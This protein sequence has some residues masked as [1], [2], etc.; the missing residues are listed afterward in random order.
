[1]ALGSSRV[2]VNNRQGIDYRQMAAGFARF[3]RPIIDAHAHIHGK[4]A[5]KV[6]AE[7]Q[8]LFGVGVTYSMTQLHLCAEVREVMGERVRF[9][10]IPTF[11]HP[12][13]GHAFRAGYLEAIQEYHNQFQA[14]VMKI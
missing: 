13:K 5:S 7:V 8:E 2:N 12:D 14:S 11:S 1:M 9:M 10:C 3:G 4:D 6:Y